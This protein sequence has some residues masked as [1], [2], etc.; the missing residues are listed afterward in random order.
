MALEFATPYQANKIVSGVKQ[1]LNAGV[2]K[3][4]LFMQS[5]YPAAKMVD[6]KTINFDEQFSIR[7]IMGT[8]A[9]PR[10]DV[11]PVGLQNFGHIETYFS[12]AKEFV[13]DGDE[14]DETLADERQ[15]AGQEFNVNYTSNYAYRL[16]QKFM[17]AEQRFENLFE[18]VATYN[19]LY[20]GY[21]SKSEYHPDITYMWGRT[22]MTTAAQIF[23]DNAEELVPAVN[24]TTSAVTAPWDSSLTIMPVIATSGDYTAGDKSWTK[25]NIDAGKA[26]PYKDVVKMVQT[27]NEWGVAEAIQMSPKA[28]EMLNYD[29]EKN[30]KEA[31]N[32]E[33][34]VVDSIRRE[35]LPRLQVIDGVTLVRVI[36]ISGGNGNGVTL[37]IYINRSIYHDRVT[38]TKTKFIPEGFVSVIPSQNSFGKAYGRI[39]HKKARYAPM[40][41]WI[42]RWI[43]DKSGV[44]NWEWHTNFV[45]TSLN[46]NS[47]ITWKVL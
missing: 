1:A 10:V 37:P 19:Q 45:M 3:R 13:T 18:L 9:S 24:L 28:Y 47:V 14:D 26:T 39:R 35:I 42:N 8:F 23:G 30:Y 20:G 6:S 11:N 38:G 16:Q 32:L 5:F 29:I 33:T 41:R 44:E 46:I 27:C 15:Y 40:A 25:T 7:N 12:Y 17:M 2:P 21:S 34:L 4:P 31:A 36:S 22:T 43:D